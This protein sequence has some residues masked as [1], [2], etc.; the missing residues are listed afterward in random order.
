M[1]GPGTLDP[2]STGDLLRALMGR[3]HGSDSAPLRRDA[4]LMLSPS[5]GAVAEVRPG[6]RATARVSQTKQ[7]TRRRDEEEEKEEAQAESLFQSLFQ[8]ED[9]V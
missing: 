4:T 6:G 8:D 1:A 3:R 2:L 9:A 7:S 5:A